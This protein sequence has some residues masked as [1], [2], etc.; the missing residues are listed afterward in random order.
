MINKDSNDPEALQ[1]PTAPSNSP[2][3]SGETIQLSAAEQIAQRVKALKL[4]ATALVREQ[5]P[6]DAGALVAELLSL[7]TQ[8]L[9]TADPGIARDMLEIAG[10]L[11][12]TRLFDLLEQVFL[13]AIQVLWQHRQA[14]VADWFVP[15]Y[16]L[17]ALYN[18]KGDYRA[19]DQVNSRIVAMA[20]ELTAP[21]DGT[22]ANVFIQLGQIYE[23]AGHP[24]AA[25]ILYRQLHRHVMTSPNFEADSRVVLV[26]EYGGVLAAAGQLD[27]ALEMYEQSLAVLESQ[28]DFDDR[29]RLQILGLTA[30]ALQQKGDLDKAESLLE[31]AR[32]TAE[33]SEY[34]DSRLASGVYHNL[35]S[36]YLQRR[37]RERYDE[38]ERLLEHARDIVATAGQ[39]NSSEYAGEISQLAVV[40]EAKGEFD[41]A[42]ALYREA[43][44]IYESAPDTNPQDFG[45]FLTDAGFLYLRLRRP[46]EAVGVF[47]RARE[48]RESIRTLPPLALAN[49]ISNLATAHFECGEYRDASRL[50]RQAI[51][52]RH[53]CPEFCAGEL[54][55]QG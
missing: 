26:G 43:F 17:A 49:T 41:R 44:R 47:R 45:D 46:A 38:A 23:Q 15:L 16:N 33:R 7:D 28:P 42:E 21:L 1:R 2:A 31:R 4:Q 50:Y 3:E 20:D 32:D 19:R 18:A 12:P 5:R 55:P 30:Q 48:I 29:H 27:T 22:T 10:V 54:S 35:A 9:T 25:A 11:L 24:K 51:D 40:V 53:Q 8:F 6:A 13:Q 36:L 39:H 14:T 34:K 52:L 37:K